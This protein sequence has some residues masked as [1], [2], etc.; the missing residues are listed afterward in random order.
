MAQG[1]EQVDETAKRKLKRI[2][3]QAL[4]EEDP[5]IFGKSVASL[6]AE[7]G[8]KVLGGCCGTDDR[9]IDDLAKRLVSDNFEPE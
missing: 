7:L 5:Q 1:K 9:H 8:L 4:V 6:H 2:E 3:G